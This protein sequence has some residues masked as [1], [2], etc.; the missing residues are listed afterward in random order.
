MSNSNPFPQSNPFGTDFRISG[1][2]SGI[3]DSDAAM[4]LQTG[5]A[6]L[7]QRILCR[8]STGRGSVI[9][10]PNDCIDIRDS[11]SDGLTADQIAGLGANVRAELLKDEQISDCTVRSTYSFSTSAL[12]MTIQV[13]SAYG[14]FSMVLFVT[15]VTV[16]LLNANLL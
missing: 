6:M 12:T 16:A 10:C 11:L 1:A 3:L 2:P 14:P 15:N 9:D 13:Q 5:R 7:A 4:S 8:L